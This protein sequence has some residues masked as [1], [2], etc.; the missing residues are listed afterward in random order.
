MVVSSH[1]LVSHALQACLEPQEVLHHR[2]VDGHVDD[3]RSAE[4]SAD[5]LSGVMAGSAG[6]S[7]RGRRAEFLVIS[8]NLIGSSRT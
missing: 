1:E 7:D 4:A 3:S 5:S 6:M 8:G 2:D